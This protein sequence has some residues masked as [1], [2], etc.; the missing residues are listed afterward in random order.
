MH[1]L[2]YDLRNQSLYQESFRPEVL[3]IDERRQA[4]VWRVVER[5]AELAGTAVD[6]APSAAYAAFDGLFQQALLRQF[7]G[8]ETAASELAEAVPRFLTLLVRR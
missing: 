3:D 4:M 5:Y 8:R 7:A 1:R 2:W 6:L